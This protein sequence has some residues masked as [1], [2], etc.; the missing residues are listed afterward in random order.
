[1]A[2]KKDEDFSRFVTMGARGSAAMLDRLEADHEHRPVELER[3]ATANKIW[4][5]KI[6]RLRLPDLLCLDCGVRFEVKT[7]SK[8]EIRTSHS[9]VPGRE[10][11]A[12]LRD[13]DLFV[14]VPW[15]KKLEEP[16]PH[17]HF[18]R[19]ADMRATFPYVKESNR[20]GVADGYELDITWPA[21]VPGPDS[22]VLE[23]DP[24]SRAV[25]TQHSSGRPYSYPLPGESPLH[26]YAEAGK[27]LVG[28][29]EFV[30]GCVAPAGDV[31]CEGETWDFRDD[32]ESDSK[33]DRYVAIK[34]AGIDGDVGIIPTLT[35]IA[36][37]PDEDPRIQLEA[38]GSIARLDPAAIPAV[39]AWTRKR[40]DGKGVD[41]ELAT[42]GV[43]VLSELAGKSAA[44][45]LSEL[46]AD[47]EVD[48]ETRSAAVW[49]LGAAGVDEPDRVLEFVADEDDQVAL[50]AMAGIGSLSRKHRNRL[51]EMLEQGSDRAA[52]S[53]AAILET[54]GPDG[55]RILLEVAMREDRPGLWARSALGHS[56]ELEVRE[57]APAPLPPAIEAALAPRWIEDES[58][59]AG[60]R[61]LG[62]FELMRRQRERH[63]GDTARAA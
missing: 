7:K 26:F 30:L 17:H 63:L 35:A 3:Y 59:M 60:Q 40:V 39:A 23:L 1:M 44:A 21:K 53:A 31:S 12:G 38:L 18:F 49:G 24:A 14:F 42:E 58:W 6:K 50:H 8:L 41:V 28:G 19:V 47:R 13:H 62:P 22:T 37:T 56:S 52:A 46:A 4:A 34:A 54:Q 9:T 45:A 32:L 15:R 57:A 61:P 5:R 25:K 16:S 11:N 27:E 36:E 33:L 43:F 55:L 51:R 2:F 20:K 48:P 10:W 29:E